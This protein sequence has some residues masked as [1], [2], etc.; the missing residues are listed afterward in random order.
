MPVTFDPDW[1]YREMSEELLESGVVGEIVYDLF[2][3]P[4]VWPP[5]GFSLKRRPPSYCRDDKSRTVFGRRVIADRTCR[6]GKRFV[7]DFP[8]G[9][10]CSMTCAQLA[11]RSRRACTTGL[12]SCQHCRAEFTPKSVSTRF[13]SRR[14]SAKSQ[15][16][17]IPT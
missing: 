7:P 3:T 2:E 9:V 10:Y 15:W 8:N 11:E 16:N 14:C 12:S 1:E 17:H 13:C 6:C 5:S 4:G